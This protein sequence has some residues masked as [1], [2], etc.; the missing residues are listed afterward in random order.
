MSSQSSR[1]VHIPNIL[2]SWPWPR[3]INPHYATCKAESSAWIES[4]GAFDEVAQEKFNR[5][6][7]SLLASLTYPYLDKEGCRIGCGLMNLVFLIDEHTD[8]EAPEVVQTRVDAVLDAIRNP[9]LPRPTG[10]W[11]GGEIA[12]Q[13]WVNAL[14]NGVTPIVQRRFIDSLQT[15]LEGVVEEAKDRALTGYPC[16]T[17]EGYFELRRKTVGVKPSYLPT[18]M[19]LDIPEHIM[20]HPVIEKLTDLSADMI[21]V[22]NDLFS[23]NKEQADGDPHNLITVATRE[24]NTDV[25]SAI[26]WAVNH[27]EY[28][29]HQFLDEWRNISTVT[30]SL[31]EQARVDVEAYC[32]RLTAWVRGHYCWSFESER[33][34]GTSGREIIGS[35][36]FQVPKLHSIPLILNDC[37]GDV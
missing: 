34:F 25:Q 17:I 21:L 3:K 20:R 2:A 37:K 10:E 7:F 32:E 28:L 35:S 27:H 8:K 33:Y 14:H 13:F 29:K 9:H 5:C 1:W 12:R 23:Y 16:R 18:E 15:Y 6:N 22:G 11:I 19:D 31:P 4:F 24:F 36:S 26:D 30:L